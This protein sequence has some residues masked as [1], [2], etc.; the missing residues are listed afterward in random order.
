MLAA[1][2]YV[3]PPRPPALNVLASI[4]D[5]AAGEYGPNIVV[6]FTLPSLATDGL[7]LKNLKSVELFIGPGPDP[8]SAEKWAAA[9]K[10]FEIPG[11]PKPG[12]VTYQ[13]PA[14]EWI[15]KPVVVGVRTIGP[16]GKISG[17]SNFPVVAVG[18][19][20]A[21][22]TDVKAENL[23]RGVGITWHGSGP[24]YRLLRG[25]DNGPLVSLGETNEP[26]WLDEGTMFGTQYTY[27]VLAVKP[28]QANDPQQ[29]EASEAATIVPTDIFPPAVPSGITTSAGTNSIDLAW[30]RNTEPDLQGYYI[31]RSVD[32]GPFERLGDLVTTPV[33]TDTRIESGKRYRYAISAV[34]TS[35]NE[36]QR[37]EPVEA[38]AP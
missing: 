12:P 30:A 14:T 5:L 37:S 23:A 15:G 28:P 13:T 7:E 4:N 31:Y 20:L 32:G 19:P 24:R 25:V 29:S 26:N 2:G 11:P 38:V 6:R 33:Y 36:S 1:C 8:F 21:R 34:D 10:K 22:P 18:T 3:G 27:R 35:G 17:W 9:A 16:T